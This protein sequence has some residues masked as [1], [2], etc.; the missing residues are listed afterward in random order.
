MIIVISTIFIFIRWLKFCKR[1]IYVID[2]LRNYF[3]ILKNVY[4]LVSIYIKMK[5]FPLYDL[6]IVHF[7]VFYLQRTSDLYIDLSN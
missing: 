5:L 3:I 4:N 6:E 1:L 7:L 2:Y